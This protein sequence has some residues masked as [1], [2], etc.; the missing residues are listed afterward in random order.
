[1]L[2][3]IVDHLL[4]LLV[5]NLLLSKH[6]VSSNASFR[7]HIL[8]LPLTFQMHLSLLMAIVLFVLL[9]L[10]EIILPEH[11]LLITIKNWRIH[12]SNLGLAGVVHPLNFLLTSQI[13][14]DT[15]FG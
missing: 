14:I 1:M 6:Y 7:V 13:F 4:L 5:L 10:E 12:F 8:N 2:L 3:I 15:L 11:H 9:A